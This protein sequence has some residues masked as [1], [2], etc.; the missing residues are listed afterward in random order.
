MPS[1]AGAALSAT[2]IAFVE[3]DRSGIIREWN[4][5]AE[6]LFGW[7]RDE[8]LGRML[9]DTLVPPQLRAAHAAAF[10]RR[11]VNDEPWPGM[12]VKVPARHRDGSQLQVTLTISPLPDGFCAFLSDETDQDQAQQELQRSTTL[13]NAILEHTSAMISAKG[14]DGSYLFVNAEYERVFQVTAVDL[15]GHNDAEVL[16]EV[17]AEAGRR[18][19]R[20]AVE[21]GE[22]VTALEELPFGDEIRQYV[23]TRFPLT[24]P[25]GSV[26]GVCSIG[27]DDTDRRR[28]E[29]ALSET[30]RRFR[31][32][33]NNVPGMLFQFRIDVD[34]ARSFLFVS[35]GSREICGYEPHELVADADRIVN[36][37][38]E[39]DREAYEASVVESVITLHP[40]RWEGTLVLRTGE[41]RWIHGVGR[42]FRLGDGSTVWDG[43]LLDR[44]RERCTALALEERRRDLDDLTRRL[45][46]YR[47]TAIAGPTGGAL[48]T[49]SF[50]DPAPVLG[51]AD[52]S[53][54]LVEA[55]RAVLDPAGHDA[56]AEAWAT[57]LGGDRSEVECEL[58]GTAVRR[59]WLRLHPR[60]VDGRRVVEGSCFDLARP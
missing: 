20:Q 19:D 3:V 56:L 33:V 39:E 16:P 53:G 47:F 55:F 10:A 18:H 9:A 57:A 35:E 50:G 45:A 21:S 31:A 54:D 26:Y 42:P 58:H 12:R 36:L 13:V 43:M 48:L 14:L 4:P 27:I 40:W 6:R 30:E 11:L 49:A 41:R 44:T 38:A 1:T 15:V 5:A 22:A 34:G 8:A 59:L 37:V 25:D 29:A 51:A 17:V 32:T 24:D 46:V 7:P 28:A 2:S 23:V 60:E 52:P